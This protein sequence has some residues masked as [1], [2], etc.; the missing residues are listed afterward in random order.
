M[1]YRDFAEYHFVQIVRPIPLSEANL[2]CHEVAVLPRAG[3]ACDWLTVTTG[4]IWS[5]GVRRC[6]DL[7]HS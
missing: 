6:G 7:S 4:I 5:G 1:V 2:Y 3:T